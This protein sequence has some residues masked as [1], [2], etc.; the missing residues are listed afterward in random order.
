MGAFTGWPARAVEFYR[1]LEADNSK[2]YWTSH[3]AEYDELEWPVA[4][5]LHTSAAE[6]R[7]AGALRASKPLTDWLDA[8][9][10][11]PAIR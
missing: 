11:P 10:G 7:V 4:P 5:W 3:R 9:V 6:T 1:G 8:H 2:A